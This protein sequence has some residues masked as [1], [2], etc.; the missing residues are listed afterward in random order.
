MD[1]F[2][3]PIG[4]DNRVLSVIP[5]AVLCLYFQAQTASL[6]ANAKYST[7][8]PIDKC[9]GCR[10]VALPGGL[11]LARQSTFPTLNHT[12]FEGD[13]FDTVETIRTD[14]APAFVLTFQNIDND[15]FAV[16]SQRYCV[17]AGQSFND[18]LQMCVVQAGQEISVGR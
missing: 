8:F 5:Q 3:G 9:G 16:D 2:A 15:S 11:E 7:S 13:T 12:M 4:L 10:S 6:L 1:V 18:T 17:Y 14:D